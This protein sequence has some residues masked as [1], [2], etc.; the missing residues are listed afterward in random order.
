MFMNRTPSRRGYVT[1]LGLT[2][3][4]ALGWVLVTAFVWVNATRW[5]PVAV[6]A[7]VFVLLL[8]A[9]TAGDLFL[10]FERYVSQRCGTDN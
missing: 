9:P 2:W 8:V 5:H 4:Y 6:G 1:V 7:C 3:M 10:S